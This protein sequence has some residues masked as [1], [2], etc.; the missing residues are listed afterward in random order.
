M[1]ETCYNL[2]SHKPDTSQHRYH[3]DSEE[4]LMMEHGQLGHDQYNSDGPL[5]DEPA[6]S[7]LRA[8]EL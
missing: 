8:H 7:S 3:A 4:P 5:Y 2:N 1:V 6:V